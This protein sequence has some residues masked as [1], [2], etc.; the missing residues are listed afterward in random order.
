[1][2]LK[3]KSFLLVGCG[4]IGRR[5]IKNLASLGARR[6]LLC[7]LSA[8]RLDATKTCLPPDSEVELFTNL[9]EALRKK[10]TAALICT[11]S[12]LHMEMSLKAAN[13]GVNLFIEKPLSHTIDGVAELMKIV[14]DNGLVA[15]MAMCYRFHPVFLRLKALLDDK[16]IG[17]LYHANCY[18]GYYLP[19]WHPK[20]DYRKEYAA[21][22]SLGGGVILTSIHG[23]DNLRWLFGEVEGIHAIV[24]RVG[25]LEMD[26][27]D[28]ALGTFKMQSGLYISWQTDFLRRSDEHMYVIVG[29]RGT[30]R[31]NVMEGLIEVYSALTK[32][33][34]KERIAFD[35]NSMY[36]DEMNA[37]LNALDKTALPAVGLEEGKA[38]LKLALDIKAHGGG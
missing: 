26:V 2:E 32:E 24:E 23:F 6:F 21:Q 13:H 29:E 19:Y 5:H 25:D 27:E 35:V 33:W 34:K 17:K 3:D 22:K 37:F 10:P 14:N 36:M 4:S 8:E 18:G 15:T 1:M 38:T 7:D 30:I 31:C 28:M 12:S 9:D 20:E 16:V 11:P